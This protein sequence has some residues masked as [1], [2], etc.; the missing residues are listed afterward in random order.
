MSAPLIP[1]IDWY[2]RPELTELT[3]LTV[4]DS[5]Q[6]FGH[7]AGWSQEH[8]SFPGRRITPPRARGG[9]GNFET[10]SLRVQDGDDVRQIP[11]GRLIM[12]CPHAGTELSARD[13]HDFYANSGA[14]AATVRAYD[15]EYGIAIAGSVEPDL[16]ELTLRRFRACGLSGDWR[17]IDGHLSLV[18]VISVGIQG[19]PIP[20]SRVAAGAPLSLVAAGAVM[21]AQSFGRKVDPA[22]SKSEP[23]QSLSV[24][25]LT[26]MSNPSHP[27]ATV[28]AAGDLHFYGSNV[29]TPTP[30]TLAAQIDR[31][32]EQRERKAALAAQRESLLAEVDDT[33]ARHAALVASLDDTADRKA[34]LLAELGD[35]GEDLNWVDE[36]G[37]LPK[38]IKRI[39]EHLEGEE[40]FDKS[41]AIATAVNAV[42]KMC[43]SGDL[44]FPGSQQVNPGSQAEACAAVAE[45]EQKKAS[46]KD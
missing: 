25:K 33:A 13:A 18:G 46:T 12:A 14:V 38:Y 3:P 2:S 23:V 9:Y 24:G 26:G 28:S 4:L 8:I 22:W 20:R 36:A 34:K 29:S 5:G 21:P 11:V 1:P 31:A 10:G 27:Y 6:I 30:A 41:R 40:G 17:A 45:W 16:D 44:N 42:K 39:A 35:D 37:G 19:F 32:I 7:V 15:D 43:S